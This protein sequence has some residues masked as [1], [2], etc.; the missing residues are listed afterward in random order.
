L[1]LAILS[2]VPKNSGGA[3][4]GLQQTMVRLG[5]SLG[6]AGTVTVFAA[7]AGDGETEELAVHGYASAF[8]LTVAIYVVALVVAVVTMRPS[9]LADRVEDEFPATV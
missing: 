6:L 2:R 4:A 3:V 5:A 8:G 9:A 1:N 7:T